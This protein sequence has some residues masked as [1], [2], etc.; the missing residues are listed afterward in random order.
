MQI[1]LLGLSFWGDEIE[2]I[3]SIDPVSGSVIMGFDDMKIY[4]ANLFVTGPDTLK[5]AIWEIQ[6]DMVKQVDYYNSVGKN[7]RSKKTGRKSFIRY[8]NDA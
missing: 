7:P 6:Q 3:E 5:E 2:S 4:P 8:R 1:M